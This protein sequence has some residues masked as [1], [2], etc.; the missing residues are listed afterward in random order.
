MKENFIA[1]QL[2]VATYEK[3]EGTETS[4]YWKEGVKL[5][6]NR[7]SFSDKVEMSK[8]ARKGRNTQHLFAGQLIGDFTKK[9][10]S[11]LKKVKPYKVRTQIWKLDDYPQFVGYG[12]LGITS[13]SGIVDIGDLIVIYSADGKKTL[14]V[15]VFQGMGNPND[16]QSAFEYLCNEKGL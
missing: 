3:K 15:Y 10:E 4:Y 5:L 11:P 6:P 16:M 14:D 12:T 1:S 8:V 7:I 9:E 13:E 2:R